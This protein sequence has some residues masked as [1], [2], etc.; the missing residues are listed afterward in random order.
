MF[1]EGTTGSPE[2]LEPFSTHS[3]TGGKGKGGWEEL[4]GL[5]EMVVHKDLIKE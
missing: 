4:E 1:R 2:K 3:T 5:P